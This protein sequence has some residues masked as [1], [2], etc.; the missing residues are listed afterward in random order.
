MPDCCLVTTKVTK[1]V[2][3]GDMGL[4]KRKA[5]KKSIGSKFVKQYGVCK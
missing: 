1:L 4:K 5:A 3:G 2:N